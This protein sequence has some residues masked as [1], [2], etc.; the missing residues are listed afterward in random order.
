MKEL[1]RFDSGGTKKDSRSKKQEIIVTFLLQ[2]LQTYL[3]HLIVLTMNFSLL[4]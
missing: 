3:K 4:N 1:T 2:F